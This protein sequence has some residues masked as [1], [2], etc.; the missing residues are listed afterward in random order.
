M[1]QPWDS[2][3]SDTIQTSKDGPVSFVLMIGLSHWV[4]GSFLTLR[5]SV[6]TLWKVPY[7]LVCLREESWNP[8]CCRWPSCN[9][10]GKKPA[11]RKSWFCAY[12]SKT[13]E[14]TGSSVILCSPGPTPC[15]NHIKSSKCP[16]PH[17]PPDL[18]QS[19]F[20]RATLTPELYL[21]LPRIMKIAYVSHCVPKSVIT[22]TIDHAL[23]DHLD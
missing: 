12:R 7:L 2:D 22:E 23:W 11:W 6:P 1:K 20:C 17:L 16:P 8:V 3:E 21:R 15:L 13:A 9:H 19:L 10:R 5:L 4:H 18:A 14:E